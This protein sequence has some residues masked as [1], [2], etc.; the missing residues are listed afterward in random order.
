[1]SRNETFK[2]Y[3]TYTQMK[4]KQL[5]IEQTQ[6]ILVIG[7][8]ILQGIPIALHF[9]YK[10]RYENKYG[11]P[12]ISITKIGNKELQNTVDEIYETIDDMETE[13]KAMIIKCK[14]RQRINTSVLIEE[15]IANDFPLEIDDKK[16][17]LRSRHRWFT[18]YKLKSFNGLEDEEMFLLAME[19]G[20]YLKE[21]F[22]LV[23][24]SRDE[25]VFIENIDDFAFVELLRK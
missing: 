25:L 14:S 24:P 11:I 22:E 7:A 17:R 1:M 3:D 21:K 8:S 12:I 9:S 4:I 5:Q 13:R 10:K 20:K 23:N 19:F 6:T 15:L 18:D 16:R 2:S